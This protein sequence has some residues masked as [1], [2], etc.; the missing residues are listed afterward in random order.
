LWFV[1]VVATFDAC[2]A[3]SNDERNVGGLDE[4][5]VATHSFENSACFFILGKTLVIDFWNC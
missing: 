3:S 4:V 1:E 5:Q 2:S